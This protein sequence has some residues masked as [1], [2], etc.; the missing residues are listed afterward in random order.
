MKKINKLL[1]VLL[2]FSVFA[3]GCSTDSSSSGNS[4]RGNSK[5]T[6]SLYSSMTLENEKKA[7]KSVITDFEKKYPGINIDPNFPASEYE[8]ILRVKM[9]AN[10]MPDLFD[11]HGWA[12]IRYG[13]YVADLSK[14][15][16]VKNLDPALDPILKDDQG[17]VYA[18][19]LNQA[20]DGI[21]YNVNILKKYKIEPPTTFGE[22]VE[23]LEQ[24]KEKSNGNVIP[25]WI[26]AGDSGPGQYYDQFATPLL[27][28]DEERDYSKELLNGTFDWSHY[29]FLS[30]KLLEMQEK[31]LIN[32][33]V[34]NAKPSQG[35]RLMAQGKIA[36]AMMNGAFGP[37]TTELNPEVKVGVIPMPAIHEGDKPSF[38][39][40]ERYTVAAWKDSKHLKEAKQFIQFI[41]QPK[42][43]KKLAEATSLPAGLTNADVNNYYSKYYKKYSDIKVQPYFDRVYL[44]SGM[45]SV[46]N[47]TGQEL[48]SGMKTPKEVSQEMAKEYKRLRNQ[49]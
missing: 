22:F 16:W 42:Y 19:P 44:P 13:E 12:K 41:S 29:N 3:A 40:G 20:K 39:G 23:A 8:G 32:K 34:L 47:K 7:F 48:L 38:I 49:K 46:I 2:S 9:A 27:I 37:N 26:P 33:D 31:G 45:W 6:L 43:V 17:K 14:M 18:Y 28:T 35:V 25:F 24:V 30:E 5:V 11:T 1:T 4:G 36:F 15:N 10:D 21:T